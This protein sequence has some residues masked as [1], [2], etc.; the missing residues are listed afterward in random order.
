MANM[1]CV[2]SRC[3]LA[4]KGDRKVLRTLL[5]GQRIAVADQHLEVAVQRDQR[6]AQVVRDVGNEVASQPDKLL[7]ELL[8]SHLRRRGP[9]SLH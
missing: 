6:R 4:T 7:L 3:W 5:R 8:H 9:S 2:P 1:K